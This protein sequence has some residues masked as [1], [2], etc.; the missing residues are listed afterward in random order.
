MCTCVAVCSLHSL[1]VYIEWGRDWDSLMWCLLLPIIIHSGAFKLP[2]DDI[3]AL[4]VD[5]DMTA[6][7]VDR[8]KT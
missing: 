6:A 2:S 7:T 3:G 8:H 5:M 1:K 4:T